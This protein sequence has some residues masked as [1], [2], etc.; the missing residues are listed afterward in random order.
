MSSPP[1]PKA[2]LHKQERRQVPFKIPILVSQRADDLVALLNS[3]EVK[4]GPIFR[5]DLVAAL[6]ALA[7][8]DAASLEKLVEDY[9]TLKVRDALVGEAK[10]AQVIELRPAK[11]GRRTA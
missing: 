6:I 7:P 9:R 11:P 5:Q 2:L 8:E 3:D 10:D 1:D 4:L